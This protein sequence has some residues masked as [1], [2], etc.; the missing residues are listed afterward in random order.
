VPEARARHEGRGNITSRI[1][2]IIARSARA[3]RPH[4]LSAQAG[5]T[6]L[7]QQLAHA[8]TSNTRTWC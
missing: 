5:K 1:I 6:V 3:A 4:R 7:M 2:D 8:I